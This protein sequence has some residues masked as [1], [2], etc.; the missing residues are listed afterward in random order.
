M[1]RTSVIIAALIGF[2]AA[3]LPAQAQETGG[4]IERIETPRIEV[5][6]IRLAGGLVD[7]ADPAP[8]PLTPDGRAVI[9][10]FDR[11]VTPADRRALESAGADILA[12]L[13]DNALRVRIGNPQALR[14]IAGVRWTGRL[15]PEKRVHPGIGDTVEQLRVIL[16]PGADLGSALS[17][18]ATAGATA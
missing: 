4:P 14:A 5:D 18:A 3:L 11:P 9:V 10:Q 15:G 1:H 8:G 12:A 13:P 7:T 2:V 16:D 6:R 17:A